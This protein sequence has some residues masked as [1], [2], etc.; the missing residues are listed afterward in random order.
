MASV[1]S[2]IHVEN[3]ARIEVD[4]DTLVD[5]DGGIVLTIGAFGAEVRIFG[6]RVFMARLR[7]A[8]IQAL[9]DTAKVEASDAADA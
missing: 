5:I 3:G 2:S 9:P 6:P 1:C 4:L 8:L 7:D